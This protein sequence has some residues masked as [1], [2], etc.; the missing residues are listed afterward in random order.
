[1]WRRGRAQA[2]A[3]AEAETGV[4]GATGHGKTLPTCRSMWS[5]QT[6]TQR[7]THSHTLRAKPARRMQAEPALIDLE[8]T[9]QGESEMGESKVGSERASKRGRRKEKR[10]SR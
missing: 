3:D 8:N 6:H 10:V 5:T 4:G 1:M 7:E 9:L 2:E